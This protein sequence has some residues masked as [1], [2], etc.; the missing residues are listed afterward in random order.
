MT[1]VTTQSNKTATRTIIQQ[2]HR[3]ANIQQTFWPNHLTPYLDSPCP[4][5]KTTNKNT[6]KN[7]HGKKTLS[8]KQSQTIPHQTDS[9]II[10]VFF[11]KIENQL[12]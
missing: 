10:R 5:K 2:S 12:N 8:D 7:K 9:K 11:R 3:I 1:A 6:F 4:A